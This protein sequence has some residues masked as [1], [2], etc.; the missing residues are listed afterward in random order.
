MSAS[1]PRWCIC[2]WQSMVAK[3]LQSAGYALHSRAVRPACESAGHTATRG[4]G[5]A[6]Q[7]A[8][9]LAKAHAAPDP[10]LPHGSPGGHLTSVRAVP[11]WCMSYN[12]CRNRHCPCARGWRGKTGWQP[13]GGAVAGA[14][15]P[16]GVHLPGEL[17]RLCLYA[18]ER[19]YDALFCHGMERDRLFA[20][21]GVHLGARTGMIAIL[22]TWGQNSLPHPHLHCIVPG[23]GISRP[24]I[25]SGPAQ[26]PVPLPV[27]APS[28]V[29]RAWMV[30]AQQG[31]SW[32]RP[33]ALRALFTKPWVVYASVLCRAG[34]WSTTWGVTP[35]R[36]LPVTADWSVA[37][38]SGC[39]SGTKTIGMAVRK[40]D[41][42]IADGVHPAFLH[43][44]PRGFVRIGTT[45][46]SPAARR[47]V[48]SRRS[49]GSCRKDHL[50]YPYQRSKS[51]GG[52]VSLL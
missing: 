10:G 16:R 8:Q 6:Q 20:G 14:V 30:A 41:G 49:S 3:R 45:A 50:P 46:S 21:D 15:L 25:G 32:R 42:A 33:A 51:P 31:L 23:G 7:A 1:R 24:A 17:N 38:R 39:A 5:W 12:S 52:G 9:P 44:L 11:T 18:P 29:M 43:I 4:T 2:T 40:G 26:G 36:S 37:M 19:V 35:T 13:A 47:A 27:K 48:I 28:R 22:H 34:R